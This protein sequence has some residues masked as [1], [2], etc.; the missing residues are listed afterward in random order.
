MDE[1]PAEDLE[2]VRSQD[3]KSRS[4]WAYILV[5]LLGII[6][7]SVSTLFFFQKIQ[8]AEIRNNA[9]LT[10]SE[11]RKVDSSQI[12]PKVDVEKLPISL[13]LLQNPMVYEW[14]GS[15]MGKIVSKGSD[16]FVVEDDSKNRIV[17]TEVMPSG[18]KFNTR[19]VIKKKD[20]SS[21]SVKLDDVPLG[22]KVISG[23]FWIFKGGKNTPVGGIFLIESED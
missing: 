9:Q 16:S 1:A 8:P 21:V 22:S 6:V 23:E 12:F 19:Y 17:I 15:I 5:H 4:F 7:G 11:T 13:E 3:S 2:V 20:G 10:A 14:R 18:I